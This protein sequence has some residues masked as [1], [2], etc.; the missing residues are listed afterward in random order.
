MFRK[1]IAASLV[2]LLVAGSVGGAL[3]LA[4]S[5]GNQQTTQ[6]EAGACDYQQVFDRTVDSVVA[7]QS[8]A[9]QGTGF[10]IDVGTN[11]TGANITVANETDGLANATY[12][13]TNAHVVGGASDVTIQFSE[14]EYRTGDVVGQSTYADLA[15]VRV[16]DAPDNVDA[17][18]VAGQD[19]QRGQ[20]VAALGNPLG[21]DQSITHGIVSG[22]NRSLPTQQGFTIP[23]VVQTDAA[24]SPGN[25]G[26][27][28]V[29][30]DGTVV[31]VNTAGIASPRAENIGFAV[32][33]SVVGEVVPDLV[34]T[35]EFDYPFLGIATQPVTPPVAD[36]NDLSESEGV[37]VTSVVENGPASGRLQG[38]TDIER[39]DGTVVPVGG[40]VILS[41]EGEE[42]TSGEDLATYLITETEP[43]ETVEL[44]V[45]RDGERQTVEVTI[46]ERPEP[47]ESQ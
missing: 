29:L 10:V 47:G 43:G 2:V 4:P 45:L 19:P 39:V 23:N 15:V 44:T 3:A 16:A 13:V 5:Q 41:I 9:G 8:E 17:L 30:C 21:L 34:A 1:Q 25:S 27:P 33:A 12:V 35:G 24:I 40:D 11:D 31:G 32:S 26:G 42:I 6:Q 28:L 37:I 38:A 36:A 22:V 46:G 7:V 14:G 20:A 18:D